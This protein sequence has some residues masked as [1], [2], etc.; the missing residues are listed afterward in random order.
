MKRNV[1]SAATGVLFGLFIAVVYLAVQYMNGTEDLKKA[2][3][4]A[5]GTGVA[6]GLLFG[7]Y[8]RSFS[9]RQAEAFKSVKARLESEGEVILDAAANHMYNGELVGGWLFL[10]DKELYFMANPMNVLSHSCR[11]SRG[12]IENVSL[13]KQMGFLSGVTVETSGGSEDFSVSRAKLW[14][15]KIKEA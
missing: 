6:A 3:F 12:S 13:M 9:K 11:I 4:T 15:E 1:S 2:V 14:L 10:T 8:I 5:V 7:L